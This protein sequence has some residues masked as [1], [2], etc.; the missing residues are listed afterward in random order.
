MAYS[1][2]SNSRWYTYWEQC[3]T[4]QFKFPTQKLKNCQIFKIADLPE[5]KITYGELYEKGIYNVL[6]EVKDAY[7]GEDITNEQMFELKQY[8]LQFMIDIEKHFK[9]YTFFRYEWYYPIRNK[10]IWKI[11]KNY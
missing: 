5:T 2:W 10:I 4:T 9:W 3:D 7:S 11:L 1:R 8:I 6:Q